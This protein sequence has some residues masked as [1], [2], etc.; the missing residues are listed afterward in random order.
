MISRNMVRTTLVLSLLGAASGQQTLQAATL[1]GN[2]FTSGHAGWVDAFPIPTRLPNWRLNLHSPTPTLMDTNNANPPNTGAVVNSGVYEPDVLVKDSFLAPGSYELTASMRSNDDDIIGLVWNY[3]DPSNYF[4]VGIRQQAAGSFGGTQGLAV[5][6]I[7]G[8]VLTQLSPAVV[9]PGA[10]SP[11]TQAMIDGRTPFD[12][13]VAVNG[14]SWDVLFNG[15]S[16]VSGVD[17][18]LAS[19][20]KIGVQSWAQESDAAAV[21]PFWGTEVETITV[22]DNTGTLFSESFTST[23]TKWRNLVMKNTANVTTAASSTRENIGNFGQD[24]N[25]PWI[26][27][28]SNGNI[29][30]T[31]TK[32]NIDFIGPAIV[33]DEPGSAAY[34]DYAMRVRMGAADNDGYGLLVRVQDDNNFYRINFHN[35]P[36]AIGTTR[37][38]RGMSVQKVLNGVWSQLY[39]DDQA[40]IPFLPPAATGSALPGA[41][42]PMFDVIVQALGNR[43]A[44]RVIDEDNNVFAYPYIYDDSLLTGTVG[45]TTWGSINTFFMGY[46]GGDGPLL[47]RIPEPSSVALALLAGL[48]LLAVRLRRS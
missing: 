1:V 3:Q 7:V 19:G 24:I 33:I 20:R 28:H 5:Q 18:D 17:S 38:P 45:L 32:P 25:D 22:T 2:A 41:G 43:L 6:K 8:G 9:G 36:A 42:V 30:A 40:D 27:Q 10:A 44:I 15:L 31:E 4:R 39:S 35:D 11:I 26:H 23:P 16:I 34:S 13:K 48:G 29:N 14:T 21:T 46:G 37:P 47:V 12:L